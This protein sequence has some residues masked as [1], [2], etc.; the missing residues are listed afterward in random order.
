MTAED[1]KEMRELADKAE[2]LRGKIFCIL[3]SLPNGS[4]SRWKDE[5]GGDLVA[6]LNRM[7]T[8]LRDR[9][10]GNEMELVIMAHEGLERKEHVEYYKRK[11]E[12]A[13]L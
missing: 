5:K 12:E 13:R 9:V 7:E 3:G 11:A 8:E 1:L 4:Y 6:E 10:R 2:D